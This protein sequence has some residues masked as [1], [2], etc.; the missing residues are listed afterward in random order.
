[1]MSRRGFLQF[2][3]RDASSAFHQVGIAQAGPAQ[4]G[5]AQI[6]AAQIDS[7]QVGFTQV[8]SDQ[9]G[10]VQVGVAQVDTAITAA[11]YE[12]HWMYFDHSEKQ[13]FLRGN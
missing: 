2:F 13:A 11:C 9:V 12:S 4:V 8:G 6:G 3:N 1:M 5:S 7:A 10:P